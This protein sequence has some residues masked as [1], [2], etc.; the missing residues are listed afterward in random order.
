MNIALRQN[1][2]SIPHLEHHETIDSGLT[3]RNLCSPWQLRQVKWTANKPHPSISSYSTEA[4]VF[5]GKQSSQPRSKFQET[6]YMYAG[7]TSSYPSPSSRRTSR[8]TPG[9]HAPCASSPTSSPPHCQTSS[10]TRPLARVSPSAS[11]TQTRATQAPAR[12]P[13]ATS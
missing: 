8:S 2:S 7:S 10:L 12:D 13:A 3:I 6:E 5:T 11:Y 9:R 4:V 1:I